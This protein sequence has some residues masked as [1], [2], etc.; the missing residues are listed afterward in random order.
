MRAKNVDRSYILGRFK[1]Y[2]S[3]NFKSA[4]EGNLQESRR[5]WLLWML[6]RAAG[7]SS[8]VKDYQLWQHNNK[9]IELYSNHVIDQK[10]NY[11]HENPVASGFVTQAY[12]WKYSS[13]IDYSGGK[14]VLDID[15]LY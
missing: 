4:I 12:H 15:Y 3:K 10:V 6:Q 5:E 14:G 11:I 8:N 1:E 9:P 13:A 2:T 7:K